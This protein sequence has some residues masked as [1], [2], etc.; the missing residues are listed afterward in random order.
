MKSILKDTEKL[1][2]GD[3]NRCEVMNYLNRLCKKYKLT[4][5]LDTFNGFRTFNPKK[6]VNFWLY[7]P[8]HP[9]DKAPIG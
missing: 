2:N 9:D 8:Q 3:K 1:S 7:E 5:S 4:V 6:P